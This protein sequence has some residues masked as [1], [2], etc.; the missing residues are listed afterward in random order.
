MNPIKIFSSVWK[1]NIPAMVNINN[2]RGYLVLVGWYFS[3]SVWPGFSSVRFREIILI[4]SWLIIKLLDYQFFGIEIENGN[5][6]WMNV[7]RQWIA[8]WFGNGPS[9]KSIANWI[10]ESVRHAFF[11]FGT[12]CALFSPFV[13]HSL[14]SINFVFSNKQFC[15]RTLILTPDST[16]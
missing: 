5:I 2:V 15:F 1:Y 4:D 13:V 14:C 11:F 9:F 3:I 7:H 8:F 12:V 16:F 10:P 6:N